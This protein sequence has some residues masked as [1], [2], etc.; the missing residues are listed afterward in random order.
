MDFGPHALGLKQVLNKVGAHEFRTSGPGSKAS[1]KQHRYISCLR[2]RTRAN[3]S[4]EQI[5]SHHQGPA[6]P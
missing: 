1:V 2:R 5:I 4:A 6:F 3:A